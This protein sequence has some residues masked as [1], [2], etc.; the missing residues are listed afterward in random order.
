MSTVSLLTLFGTMLLLAIVPGP[1][2]FAIIARS[3]SSGILRGAYM[4]I[5]MILADYVFI[6]LA[7][8]GL[9]ALS[10]IMGTAFYVIKY[11]S[12]AYLMWLGYKLLKTK[13]TAIDIEETKESSLLSNLVTGL[14][15][16]LGN[17]KAILFYVGFFP[18]FVNI[19]DVSVYDT[20]LIMLTATVAFGSVNLGYAFLA[21]KAKGVFKSSSASNVINKTAG[22]IMV[23]TGVLVAVRA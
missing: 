15:I 4:V 19:G 23:S 7:L 22:T 3:F 13:A 16:T 17:P 6:V 12:A 5:G 8:F 21:V 14:L 2:V 11:I 10:E 9:S 18:A 1:G 20:V